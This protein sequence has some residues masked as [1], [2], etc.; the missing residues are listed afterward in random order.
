MEQEGDHEVPEGPPSQSSVKFYQ[1]SP[2]LHSRQILH[3]NSTRISA[4]SIEDLK[5]GSGIFLTNKNKPC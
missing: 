5:K 2:A 1:A 3:H 4:N